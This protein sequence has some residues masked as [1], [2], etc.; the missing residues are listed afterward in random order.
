MRSR[1]EIEADAAEVLNDP[2]LSD[3]MRTELAAAL[4]EAYPYA[5]PSIVGM[6]SSP[7]G[8]TLPVGDIEGDAIKERILADFLADLYRTEG[9]PNE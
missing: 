1:K 6:S 5:G 3:E 4:A 2:T 8:Q 7:Y 9:E